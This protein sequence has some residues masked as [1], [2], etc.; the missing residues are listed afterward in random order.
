MAT[1]PIM[2]YDQEYLSARADSLVMQK[3]TTTDQTQTTQEKYTLFETFAKTF[4]RIFLLLIIRVNF[5]PLGF[6]KGLTI[7]VI[8]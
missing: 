6:C 3:K 4:V 5:Q 1:A 8:A 7:S 2:A